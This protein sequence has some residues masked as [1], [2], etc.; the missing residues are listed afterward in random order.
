MP[1]L[2]VHEIDHGF[3][4]YR[5]TADAA[6]SRTWWIVGSVVVCAVSTLSPRHQLD[7]TLI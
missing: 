1:T 5:V 4:E 7:Y 3:T 6:K 2:D